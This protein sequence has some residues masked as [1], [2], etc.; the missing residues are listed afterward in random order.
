MCVQALRDS[1]GLWLLWVCWGVL[2][3]HHTQALRRGD[4]RVIHP[5]CTPNS[6]SSAGIHSCQAWI[7]T[8][9]ARQQGVFGSGV[10]ARLVD[11]VGL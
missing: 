4:V 8:G 6:Q 2:G 7:C 3:G 5:G 10:K 11:A 1:P 9:V